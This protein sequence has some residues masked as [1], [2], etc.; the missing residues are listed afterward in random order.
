LN[1]R[2][3]TRVGGL[4][5]GRKIWTRSPIVNSLTWMVNLTGYVNYA[6]TSVVARRGAARSVKHVW[7]HLLYLSQIRSRMIR[8]SAHVPLELETRLDFQAQSGEPMG[9]RDPGYGVHLDED[10]TSCR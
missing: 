1:A 9:R 2:V 10:G 4:G 5:G 8:G 7:L 3:E 6:F